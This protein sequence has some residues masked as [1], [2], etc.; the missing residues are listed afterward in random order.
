MKLRGTY[1]IQETTAIKKDIGEFCRSYAD[2]MVAANIYREK[3]NLIYPIQEELHMHT[4]SRS[5]FEDARLCRL[6][7]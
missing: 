6:V 7:K 2:G 1:S 5:R 3:N 4:H